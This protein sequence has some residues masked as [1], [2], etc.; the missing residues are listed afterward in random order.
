MAD[1]GHQGAG[2]RVLVPVKRQANGIP[3]E[4]NNR[5][6]NDLLT[7]LRVLGERAMSLLKTCWKAL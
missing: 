4:E 6:Y 7:R 5:A 1:K 2:A 3:L